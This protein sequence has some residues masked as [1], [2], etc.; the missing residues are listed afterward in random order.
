MPASS[1]DFT[2]D[3][4]RCAA[5]CCLAFAFDRSEAFGHDKPANSA[6]HY[7]D[8][9][10]RCTIHA[11]LA[12]KGYAGCVHF[13]CHGAGQRVV[14]DLFGGRDWKKEPALLA[15]MA[16]AFRAMRR[17]HELMMMLR[18]AGELDL[19]AEAEAL[20]LSLMESLDPDLGWTEQSLAEFDIDAADAAISGFLKSLA[21]RMADS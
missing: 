15:P 4:D 17:L 21:F 6:C 19:D 3:C 13:D 14:Q 18:A 1:V 10:F 5:L 16:A 11:G 7:L 20:R 12:S 8:R 9:G 2:A